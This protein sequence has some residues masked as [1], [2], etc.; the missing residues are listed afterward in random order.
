MWSADGCRGVFV[1]NGV[2][3]VACES[4]QA[5]G[6]F[7]VNATCS[8]APE[9]PQIWTRSLRGGAAAVLF[10][11]AREEAMTMQLPFSKVRGRDWDRETQLV[12]KNLWNTSVVG[13]FVGSFQATVPARDSLFVRLDAPQK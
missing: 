12:V 7:P 11:N 2:H 10:M 8:C 13:N 9:S 4:S 5:G 3:D 1:C 6:Y